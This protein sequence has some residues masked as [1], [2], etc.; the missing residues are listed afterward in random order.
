MLH[1]VR[2]NMNDLM[3]QLRNKEYPNI[4]DVAYAVLETNGSISVIPKGEARPPTAQELGTPVEDPHYPV[5]L[6]VDGQ[7]NLR[8]L[9]VLGIT[10]DVLQQQAKAQQIDDLREVFYA[11][12]NTEGKI[13]FFLEGKDDYL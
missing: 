6:I 12:Y 8:N 5:T 4:S 3:E 1:R 2:I 10:V 9:Q 7:V 13:D 11:Q